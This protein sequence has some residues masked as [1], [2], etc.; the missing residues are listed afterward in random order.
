M[1][2][3]IF[4]EK[5]KKKKVVN[6]NPGKKIEKINKMESLKMEKPLIVALYQLDELVSEKVTV[7][8]IDTK[9]RNLIMYL[10]S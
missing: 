9:D 5:K 4:I 6:K 3:S 2:Y 7:Y 8:H 10:L 1:H